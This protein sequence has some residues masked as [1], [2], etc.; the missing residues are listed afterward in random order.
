MSRIFNIEEFIHRILICG[1]TV[2][3]LD[4]GVA[5]ILAYIGKFAHQDLDLL[6]LRNKHA[7]YQFSQ[8]SGSAG[9][10]VFCVAHVNS[11]LDFP[12]LAL[13]ADPQG[14]Q[15]Y[16]ILFLR[17]IVK[18]FVNTKFAL[19]K[20]QTHDYSMGTIQDSK[21]VTKKACDIPD[22]QRAVSAEIRC[23][24]NRKWLSLPSRYPQR[25]FPSRRYP[26][27]RVK[28]EELSDFVKWR[29]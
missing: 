13:S 23:Y 5:L 19:D 3:D 18:C 24:G 12:Y 17:L 16:Y 27:H 22:L 4:I 7:Y 6:A 15:L 20:S 29:S 1:Y 28:A 2:A 25:E 10:Q 9:H 26:L 21:A 8:S 14:Y 11:S